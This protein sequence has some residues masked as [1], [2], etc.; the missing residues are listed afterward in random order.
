VAGKRQMEQLVQAAA[1]IDG[2]YAQ[3]V[4][5]PCTSEVLLVLSADSTAACRRSEQ[6]Y[7]PLEPWPC[8]GLT[9]SGAPSGT[10]AIS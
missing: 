7:T 6:K 1:D 5:V 3:R 9:T 8:R 2:F 4:P 10:C